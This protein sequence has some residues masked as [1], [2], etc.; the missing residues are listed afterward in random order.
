MSNGSKNIPASPISPE[1]LQNS[2]ERMAKIVV[3][4]SWTSYHNY[5]KAAEIASF[6]CTSLVVYLTVPRHLTVDRAIRAAIHNA[7]FVYY[8]ERGV[9][10]SVPTDGTVLKFE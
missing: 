5:D 2:L 1:R 8:D 4:M 6:T 10:R 7:M 3:G 9:R